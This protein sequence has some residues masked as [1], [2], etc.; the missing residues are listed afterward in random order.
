VSR[1]AHQAA[2]LAL[3][4]RINSLRIRLEH[5]KFARDADKV[6]S[7]TR[8]LALAMGRLARLRRKGT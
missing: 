8:K 7:L 4:D 1:R 2:I 5:A 3:E 6:D